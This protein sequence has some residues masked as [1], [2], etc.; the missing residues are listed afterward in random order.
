MQVKV[1]LFASFRAGRF[2]EKTRDCLPGTT[3]SQIAQELSLPD[4]DVR[5]VLVNGRHATVDQTL[6]E[7]DTLSFF[8]PVG[9][10]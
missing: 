7:G 3:V 9:G 6:N 1:R 2:K 4:E 10:G 5:I 8:P